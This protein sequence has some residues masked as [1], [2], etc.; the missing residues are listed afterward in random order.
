MQQSFS[1]KQQTYKRLKK[2]KGAVFGLCV[3]FIALFIS[4][5]GYIIAPD[6]SPNAYLQTV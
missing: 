2:N 6:N 5:F 3:I 1:F 4:L